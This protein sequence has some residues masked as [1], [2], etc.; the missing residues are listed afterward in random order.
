MDRSVRPFAYCGL[1]GR[2]VEL[3][4]GSGVVSGL[5]RCPDCGRW[6]CSRCWD[7][8]ASKCIFCSGAL[9]NRADFHP[10]LLKPRPWSGRRYRWPLVRRRKAPKPAD[11]VAVPAA[12]VAMRPRQ[13]RGRWLPL[14]A[15]VAGMAVILGSTVALVGGLSTPS[16]QVAGITD[17]PSASAAAVAPA[18]PVAPTPTEVP[19]PPAASPSPSPVATST[20][21]ASP[22]VTS[23]GG[24]LAVIDTTVRRAGG[25]D[26]RPVFHVVAAVV[27]VSPVPVRLVASDATYRLTVGQTSATGRFRYVVPDVI[28][29]AEVGYLVDEVNADVVSR[30]AEPRL[31]VV[32]G[33][34]EPVDGAVERLSVS[35]VTWTTDGGGLSVRGSV[36]NVLG[37]PVLQGVVGAIALDA[38]GRPL[39]GLVDLTQLSPLD[40]GQTRSFALDQ[41]ATGPIDRATIAD[42]AVFAFDLEG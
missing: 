19:S 35:V 39:A 42:V 31:E 29:P 34:P 8:D 9:A 33:Q 32:P 13:S 14:V 40:V 30:G 25:T 24:D 26:A 41:P 27:N 12:V 16:G 17:R 10:A 11:P 23:P 1:C 38:D 36:T 18:S 2:K 7:A 3:G 4:G 5:Q 37:R 22:D 15:L 28:R 6:V 21:S 20:P